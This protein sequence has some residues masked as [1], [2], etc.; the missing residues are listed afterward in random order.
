MARKDRVKPTHYP[1][2]PFHIIRSAQLVSSLIVAAIMS[3]FLR[4]LARDGYRLP[5]TFILLLSVSLL[6]IVSL[7][8]TI[9]LHLF[10][11]LNPLLNT[12][13]NAALLLLW[14]VSFS[15]LSW[16]SSGTLRHFCTRA[17]WDDDTGVSICRTYKALFSFS[18]IGLV[19]TLVALVLD[20]HVQRGVTRRGKFAKVGMG[21]GEVDK[22]G[23]R[24][25]DVEEHETN[26][27]PSALMGARKRGGEGYAVPEEQFAYE[28]DLGYHGAAGQIGRRS[29]E[30]RI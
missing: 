27:N 7:T 2:L 29:V 12:C 26:P 14:A 4:E 13:L 1:F 18:L 17:N 3:Y 16:W 15:L 30:E 23:V 9:L 28:E 5:W 22:G 10:Y 24:G 8:A 21:L 11:G 19:A 25:V 6:T 20:V